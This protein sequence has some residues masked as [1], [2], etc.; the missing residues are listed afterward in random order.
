MRPAL[1]LLPLLSAAAFAQTTYVDDPLTDGTFPT[2]GGSRGGSFSPTGWTVMNEPDTVWYTITDALESARVEYTVTGLQLGTSLSGNDHD[3]LTVYQAPDGMTEPIAY[4]P[5]FRNNDFKAF[6][7]IFGSL[8]TSRPGAMKLEI[9]V[10][11][12]GAPWYHDS[13]PASCGY[14]VISYA[15]NGQDVGWDPAAS[16]RMALEW[17]GG[18]MSFYRDGNLLGSV[19]Y[20][21]TYA[22]QPLTVR[23]GSPRH[24]NV[25]PGAAFMPIGITIKD[26][27]ITGTAGT[28]TMVCGAPPPPPPPP[29]DAGTPL[30]PNT[31]TPLADVTAASWLPGVFDDPTDLNVEGDGSAPTGVVYLRFPGFSGTVTRAVLRLHTQTYASAA[32]SSGVLCAVAD[33]T[34][35]ETAMTWVTRPPAG[36]CTGAP[37]SVTPDHD[38]DFDV[39]PLFAAGPVGSIALVSTDSDGAHFMSKEGGGAAN[40]PKLMLELVQLADAGVPPPVPADAGVA[41]P[42]AGAP[43][44]A[45]A[46]TVSAHDGGAV[47]AGSVGT[48]TMEMGSCGCHAG[49]GSLV[50]LLLLLVRRRR[51]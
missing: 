40:G 33:S 51:A 25:Y 43:A 6:T 28:R 3:I 13:C 20:P 49:P 4:L 14:D 18:T 1:V 37:I 31:L 16:Y 44:P 24:D 45:D 42:D 9:A 39:T 17:G 46:G 27:K 7:R 32:G 30:P 11:P 50:M 48:H 15:A 29:A 8:E 41:E 12:Q 38:F 35:S 5:G 2:R 19:Q 34:W 47:D 10:C 26:V 36:L 22:P 23:L 21:D